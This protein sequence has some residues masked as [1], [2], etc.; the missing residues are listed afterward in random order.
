MGESLLFLKMKENNLNGKNPS[1]R[2]D[3]KTHEKRG[4]YRGSYLAKI[5]KEYVT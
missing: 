5:L 1:E 4:Y 3:G 2:T